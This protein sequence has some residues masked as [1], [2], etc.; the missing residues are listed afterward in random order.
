MWCDCL[1]SSDIDDDVQS[2]VFFLGDIYCKTC[3]GVDF[4]PK[5]YGF[6]S[7]AGALTRTQ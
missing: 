2:S 3:C 5:G 7:G 4:G 1:R 6:G